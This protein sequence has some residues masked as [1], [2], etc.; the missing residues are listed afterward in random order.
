M[1]LIKEGIKYGA[2][3]AVAREGIKAFERHDKNQP[4]QR[5]QDPLPQSYPQ[6]QPRQQPL[7]WRDATGY[8]HQGWCNGQCEGRC[9]N[10]VLG[11]PVDESEE[12][13]WRTWQKQGGKQPPAY[14]Q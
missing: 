5:G 7:G 4:Q 3:F 8:V 1:G 13:A 11:V 6:Q 9:N 14:G 12:Q 2:I 10:S